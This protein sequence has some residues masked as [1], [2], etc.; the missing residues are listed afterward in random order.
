M[1][2]QT[3][4]KMICFGA[5]TLMYMSSELDK[6][7]YQQDKLVFGVETKVF[8]LDTSGPCE[9]NQLF[10]THFFYNFFLLRNFLFQVLKI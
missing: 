8:A 7:M 1:D 2:I 10:C 3:P 9:R 6:P 5:F 4:K